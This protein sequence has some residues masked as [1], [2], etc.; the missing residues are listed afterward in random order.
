VLA[1]FFISLEVK[2][3]VVTI[4]RARGRFGLMVGGALCILGGFVMLAAQEPSPVPGTS[5]Q[6]SDSAATTLREYGPQDHEVVRP[7]VIYA[8]DPEFSDKARKKKLGGVCVFSVLIDAQGN[9]Q[10][11]QLVKSA[12]DGV[13]QKQRS[14]AQSLD[15]K[16]MEAVRQYRFQPATLHGKPVPYRVMIEVNFRIY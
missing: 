9:P 15:Q 1:R 2:L 6:A 4:Y 16:G 12:A 11:L 3:A 8:P 10:D 13:N 7:K 5:Q 14:A